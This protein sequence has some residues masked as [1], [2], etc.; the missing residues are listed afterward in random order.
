MTDVTRPALRYHGSK[1]LAAPWIIGH[2]PDHHCYVELFGGGAAVLLR[3]DPS[4]IEVY[5]DSDGEIVNFFRVLRN[6]PKQLLKMLELTPY[7]RAE[8]D[9]SY[10]NHAGTIER[11]RRTFVRMWQGHQS[12]RPAARPSWRYQKSPN[13]RYV[14]KDFTQLGFLEGAIARFREVQIECGS[15]EDVIRRFDTPNTLFYCDP[16]YVTATRSER[17]REKAYGAHEFSDEDHRALA[18]RL[19]G[20]EGMAVVSGYPSALYDEL[21]AGWTRTTKSMAVDGRPHRSGNKA[22]R[23]RVEALWISP[24][25]SAR[26]RQGSMFQETA[27]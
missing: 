16:P 15:Y 20:I 14:I 23:R 19:K 13:R 6:R 24:A 1:W 4:P 11:A 10:E 22:Q 9:L 18:K 21:Y 7:A 2:F 17:W 27:P 8:L 25:A 5:N 3:K 26:A 12:S